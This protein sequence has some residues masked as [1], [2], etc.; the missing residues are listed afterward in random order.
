MINTA[1]EQLEKINELEQRATDL[2]AELKRSLMLQELWSQ[3]FE[4]GKATT[5]VIGNARRKMQF[6][7]KNGRGDVREF[8]LIDV[9]VELW[10]T[11]VI[12]DIDAIHRFDTKY[13]MP[14]YSY[15]RDQHKG[16]S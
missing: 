2:R 8:D 4:Y 13:A 5:Q 16:Q 12:A 15:R 11:A 10:S 1:L 14:L 7:I 6:T 3:V 9:P